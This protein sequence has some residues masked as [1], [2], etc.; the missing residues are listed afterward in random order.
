MRKMHLHGVI[1]RT[2]MLGSRSLVEKRS[3]QGTMTF[4]DFFRK[5]MTTIAKR[6][7]E[8]IGRDERLLKLRQEVNSLARQYGKPDTY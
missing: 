2:P 5:H 4:V 6:F 1:V 7:K 3:E 8:M